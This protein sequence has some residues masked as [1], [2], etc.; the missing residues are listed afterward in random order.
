MKLTVKQYVYTA[1]MMMAIGL[2]LSNMAM[3]QQKHNSDG[4]SRAISSSGSEHGSSDVNTTDNGRIS[5][6]GQTQSN[7]QSDADK[8][9]E[10]NRHE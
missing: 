3:A 7:T 9:E 6:D 4:Q 2:P 8:S 5:A 10:N 1:A